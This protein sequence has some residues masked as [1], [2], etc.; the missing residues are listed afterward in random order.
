M[1]IIT[2]APAELKK[3]CEIICEQYGL[4]VSSYLRMCLAY[5]NRNKRLPVDILESDDE[6]DLTANFTL[7]EVIAMGERDLQEGRAVILNRETGETK[8]Y[9]CNRQD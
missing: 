3:Q 2:Q 6:E 9:V 8:P 7:S 4:T 5:L 1:Q